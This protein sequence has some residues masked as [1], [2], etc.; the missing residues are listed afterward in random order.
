MRNKQ[1]FSPLE[2][3]VGLAIGSMV[4]MIV[5]QSISQLSGTFSR[6][7]TLT[8]SD[9]AATLGLSV[10]EQDFGSLC[11][12]EYVHFKEK[13]QKEESKKPI[14]KEKKDGDKQEEKEYF[15]KACVIKQSDKNMEECS[16]IS[17]Y[18]IAK[19]HIV[20]KKVFY[21]LEPSKEVD[22]KTYTLYRQE[23]GN[24]LAEKADDKEGHKF[25]VMKNIASLTFKMWARPLPPE[26]DKKDKKAPEKQPKK[27]KKEKVKKAE[28]KSFNEWDSDKNYKNKEEKERL[29]LLPEFIDI[30]L[31]VQQEKGR[32]ETYNTTIMTPVG[33]P[34]LVLEDVVPIQHPKADKEK[35]NP[36]EQLER[37][38]KENELSPTLLDKTGNW[39]SQVM[40]KE[41]R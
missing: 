2:I 13:D 12:P 41:K 36:Q 19:E 18:S 28:Y 20:P 14:D 15:K 3:I 11:M 6:T 31:V 16:V 26:E 29:P 40:Q 25:V 8:Q 23:C 17:M 27:E 9:M 24:L 35:L 1:G 22:N 38:S 39:T 32:G 34:E 5:M 37:L 33:L 10:L 30:T 7:V 21:T 4:S